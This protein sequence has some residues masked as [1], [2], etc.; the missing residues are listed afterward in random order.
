MRFINKDREQGREIIKIEVQGEEA[1][2]RKHL[3]RDIR[4]E[5]DSIHKHSFPS[6]K[7]FQKIPCNCEE[8]R[9]SVEPFEHD[10]AELEDRKKKNVPTAECRKSYMSV[11]VQQLL[12]GVVSKPMKRG[13]MKPE[14]KD[15]RPVQVT[16]QNNPL[17]TSPTAPA[18]PAKKPWYLRW[19][20]ILL[21][22]VTLLAG[23]AESTG[24]PLSEILKLFN[25]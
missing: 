4:Q 16:I 17:P 22:T 23:L 18:N 12:D 24:Y 21:G 2:D 5:V 1:E 15:V 3:L 11:P 10:Y 9:E 19:W 6:L 7:V 8:C 25:K 20:A 14:R 13:D